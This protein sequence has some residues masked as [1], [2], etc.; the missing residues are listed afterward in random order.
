MA[1]GELDSSQDKN[2][3][4]ST[5]QSFVPEN[6]FVELVWEN[7]QISMQGQSSRARKISASSTLPPYLL[8]SNTPKARD[9]DRTNTK[10]GKF[11]AIDS[12]SSDMPMS[13]PTSEM[14]LNQDDE[15]V[16]WFN[17]PVDQSLQDEYSDFL[18]ELSGVTVNEIPTH[19]NFALL[20]RRNQS[21]RDSCTVSLNNSAGY[22]Q[23]NLSKVPTP[24]DAEAKPRSATT[25]SSTLPSLLCQTSSPYLR[26]RVLENT[27]NSVGHKSTHRAICGESIGVQTSDIA[28]P[29]IKTQKLDSVQPCNNTV[30]MNFPHFSRPSAVVKASLQNISAMTSIE[31]IGSKEKGS[32]TG[33]SGP[34]DSTLFDSS[35]NIQKDR[36]SHCQP[37]IVPAKTDIKESEAKS[38][39]EPVAVKPTDAISEEN[40]LKNDKVP[41]QVIG[42][43]ASKGLPDGDKT[44][45]P[46]LAASS[47]CSRN[48][49]ER[50]SDDPVHNLKRKNRENEESECPSEDAEESV[51]VK[52]AFLARGGTGSKR[53]RAAE[54]HNLS[55]RRRRDRINEKMRALQELIPN[56]NKVDKASMLDE[57]I[58]YLKTLQLQVQI[59]S[60]GAGLYMPPMMLPSGMQHMHAAHMAHF[61]PMGVGMGM[62]MGMG[63]GMPL[64]DIN[65][66]SS[67]CPMVQVPPILGAPFSGA[68]PQMSG[69]TALHGMAGSNLQLFGLPGQGLPMSMPHAPLIPISGGHLMKS[70]IGTSG[71]GQVGALNNIDLATASSSKD[72]MQNINSQVAHNTNVHS[73]MNQAPRQCAQTDQSFEQPVAVQENGQA[74]ENTGGMPY[75]SADDNEKVPDSLK[76]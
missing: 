51:G 36:I 58:E 49:V 32:A 64:Q 31:R 54:V 56:C 1:R 60:M 2:P 70:S 9:K 40:V 76:P 74:S 63:F 57:A 44:V 23:G 72:P 67:A 39:D 20:N 28:L 38:L 29:G 53:S 47:V 52:K 22:E 15:V 12:V 68:G 6:D 24:A 14:S 16:P 66:A 34:P 33:I 50:A 13:V 62:G 18:S 48:S 30:L 10:V 19:S 43:N 21:I 42:E 41:S 59:M 71:S 45:K 8:S 69:P 65:P 3:P 27:G 75:R 37:K 11:G 5:D 46:V 35:I 73:S 26:S 17:Y 7:G 4:G 55:E 25:Q 61:A